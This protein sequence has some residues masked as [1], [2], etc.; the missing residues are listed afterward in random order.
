MTNLK[1]EVRKKHEVGEA[2]RQAKE[3]ENNAAAA[4]AEVQ[5]EDQVEDQGRLVQEERSDKRL[6]NHGQQFRACTVIHTM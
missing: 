5:R 4:A 1:F 2:G 3:E 6:I